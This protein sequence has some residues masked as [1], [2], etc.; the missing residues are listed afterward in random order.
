MG[1]D[2][3]ASARKKKL[4]IM[5]AM[6]S[7]LGH[8]RVNPYL[9]RRDELQACWRQIDAPVLYIAAEESEHYK[10]IRDT[11]TLESLQK[12]FRDV[13]LEIVQEAGTPMF[14]AILPLIR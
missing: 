10:R 4:T 14:K 12:D 11:F 3:S 8:K 13:R 9:Y 6:V 5:P 7:T 2:F 1:S